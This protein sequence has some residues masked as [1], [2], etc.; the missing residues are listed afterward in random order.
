MPYRP[1]GGL[2]LIHGNLTDP[3]RITG[4]RSELDLIVGIATTSWQVDGHEVRREPFVSAREQLIVIRVNT[5]HP[6]GLSLTLRMDRRTEDDHP[7]RPESTWIKPPD[8]V[9]DRWAR[10]PHLVP[11][12]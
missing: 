1:V 9:I 5:G 6:D 4:Y 2:A 8:T 10:W 7:G 3:A 12:P 11:E